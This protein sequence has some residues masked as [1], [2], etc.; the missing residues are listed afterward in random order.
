MPILYGTMIVTLGNVHTVIILGDPQAGQREKSSWPD[1]L[2]LGLQGSAT[3]NQPE[4]MAE[5]WISLINT[6]PQLNV[7]LEKMPGQ[8]CRFLNKSWGAF[9]QENMVP[10]AASC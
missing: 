4:K 3:I 2:P 7:G 8:N 1:K 10:R 6:R 9:N 5:N